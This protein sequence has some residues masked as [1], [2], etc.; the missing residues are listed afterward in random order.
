MRARPQ[1]LKAMSAKNPERP[2]K[3]SGPS[4]TPAIRQRVAS[5]PIPKGLIICGALGCVTD[6]GLAQ[7]AL[8]AE[9]PFF[10]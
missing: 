3:P 9:P 1:M 2:S 7:S 8:L 10:D 6:S 4:P 5:V